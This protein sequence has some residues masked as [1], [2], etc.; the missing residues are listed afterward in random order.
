[1]YVKLFGFE[2]EILKSFQELPLEYNTWLL[3]RQLVDIILLKWVV[4]SLPMEILIDISQRFLILLHVRIR[5]FP[6]SK[7]FIVGRT[8]HEV[9]KCTLLL[10]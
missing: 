9:N 8:W 5:L 10:R 4:S 6:S 1:M 3:F 2:A 7:R